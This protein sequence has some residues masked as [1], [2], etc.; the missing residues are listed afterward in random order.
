MVCVY[1]VWLVI[2]MGFCCEV[3]CCLVCMVRNSIVVVVRVRFSSG[4]VIVILVSEIDVFVLVVEI[5]GLLRFFV[6]RFEVL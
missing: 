3:R 6:S 2:G 1:D 5:M 4:M